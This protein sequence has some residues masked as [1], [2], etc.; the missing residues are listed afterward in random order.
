MENISCF[1]ANENY[2]VEREKAN[3]VEK[4]K[5]ILKS[6]FKRVTSNRICTHGGFDL[7]NERTSLLLKYEGRQIM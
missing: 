2:T 5:E 7:R 1:Y 4:K 3:D 6:F